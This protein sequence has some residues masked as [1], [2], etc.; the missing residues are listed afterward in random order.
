MINLIPQ[1]T[2]AKQVS[3]LIQEERAGPHKNVE[4]VTFEGFE[5]QVSHLFKELASYN[6]QF[7]YTILSNTQHMNK[8][9]S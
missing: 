2:L 8:A 1:N 6:K 5:V 4:T 9:E 7:E 3:Q